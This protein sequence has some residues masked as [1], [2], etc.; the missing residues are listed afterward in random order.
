MRALVTA[1]TVAVRGNVSDER[2]LA[3]SLAASDLTQMPT[4][5]GDIEHSGGDRIETIACF[6]FSD[7]T[8]AGRHTNP[9]E[10]AGP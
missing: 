10:F 9:L 6:A 7:D 4:F 1:V 5:A 3:K 2:D 8:G